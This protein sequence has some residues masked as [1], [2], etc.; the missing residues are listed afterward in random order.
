MVRT[1]IYLDKTQK[2]ALERLSMA[3][4]I[5]MAELIRIAVGLLLKEQGTRSTEFEMLLEKTF[6]IWKDRRDITDSTSFVR[7]G[8]QDW[9]HRTGRHGA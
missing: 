5:S 9:T 8:R 2:E 1:Q 3:H 7:R 6:G 4:G